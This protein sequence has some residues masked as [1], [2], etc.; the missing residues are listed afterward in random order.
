MSQVR[1]WVDTAAA[2]T[3]LDARSA[4]GGPSN[5]TRVALSHL[6]AD[7]STPDRLRAPAPLLE[8]TDVSPIPKL[9]AKRSRPVP[10]LRTPRWPLTTFRSPGISLAAGAV[11]PAGLL[12]GRAGG[13]ATTPTTS[14]SL[15]SVGLLARSLITFRFCSR[16]NEQRKALTWDE[17]TLMEAVLGFVRSDGFDV[18]YRR[19]HDWMC[20]HDPSHD[21]DECLWRWPD[22]MTQ[23]VESAR[24]RT[25]RQRQPTPPHEGER[26]AR[27]ARRRRRRRRGPRH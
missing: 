2:G 27:N 4:P 11:M 3:V 7:P 26:T 9:A 19:G 24:R 18:L 13:L 6:A 10:G 15:W 17:V 1:A 8:S 23:F 12:A 25:R 16:Q 21:E 20:D 5:A 14:R 22:P